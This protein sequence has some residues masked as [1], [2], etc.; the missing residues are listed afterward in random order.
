MITMIR[1]AAGFAALLLSCAGCSG[2]AVGSGNPETIT[3]SSDPYMTTTS[4]SQ[5]LRI[6]VRTSPQPPVRG[7]NAM[8]LT[9]TDVASGKPRDDLTIAVDPWMPAM[10]HGSSAIPTVTPKGGG[11]Y[12]VTE[13][14][15]FM[16]GHWELRTSFSSA[17]TTD[18]AAPAVD[19]P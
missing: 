8:E 14:D 13:V 12:V 4:D 1:S 19:I 11:N 5:L 10:N 7:T 3:F 15:L 2:R 18:H 6:D 9:V 16:P 17:T